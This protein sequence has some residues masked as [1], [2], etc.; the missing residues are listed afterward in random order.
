MDIPDINQLITMDFHSINSRFHGLALLTKSMWINIDFFV[1]AL[2]GNNTC[3]RQP[4]V[5]ILVQ[6]SNSRRSSDDSDGSHNP[7]AAAK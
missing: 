5:G 6:L 2:A 1:G 7:R 4:F 3:S